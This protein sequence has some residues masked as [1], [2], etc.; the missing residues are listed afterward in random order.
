MI[1]AKTN[2]KTC[3]NKDSSI[4]KAFKSRWYYFKNYK[5]EVFILRKN[6]NFY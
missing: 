2:Y 6:I 5:Y 3:K 4:I 1:L